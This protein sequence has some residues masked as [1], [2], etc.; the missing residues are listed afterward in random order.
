MNNSYQNT[1]CDNQGLCY[2]PAPACPDFIIKQHDTRPVFKVDITDCD[3]PIDLTDLI[4][5]ASMWTNAKLKTALTINDNLI[6]F[7]DN[8]GYDSV[9]PDSIL[10][11]SSGRDFERMTVVGFDDV[12]KVIQ[13]QR[14]ACMD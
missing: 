11:V 10:H 3:L 6:K 2:G 8:I 9:D 7:A 13:V 14:G 1:V 4:V 12:N 5:E